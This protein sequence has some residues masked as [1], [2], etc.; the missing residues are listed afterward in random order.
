SRWLL[1][2]GLLGLLV[3]GGFWWRGH[4]D[5]TALAPSADTQ[6]P[7]APAANADSSFTLSIDSEPA[8]ATVS[9]GSVPLGTTPF[10]LTLSLPE[11]SSPRV[12]VIEKD[13][14]QPYVV[15]QSSAHG[16]VRVVAALSL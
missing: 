14:Y 2:V 1:P 11:G 13:G 5:S 10:S 3:F 16:Q 4:K 9:E 6:A 8:G 12:F 7:S 15:R